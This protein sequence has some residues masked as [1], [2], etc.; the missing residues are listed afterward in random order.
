MLAGST[1]SAT[2]L[3]EVQG[4]LLA[5]ARAELAGSLSGARFRYELRYSGQ[6]FEL[7]V[8]EELEST[9]LDALEHTEQRWAGMDPLALRAAFAAAHEQRYGYRD[10]DAE[11]ELVNVRVSVWGPSPPLSPNLASSTPPA[12]SERPIV[13]D[14]RPLQAS[15]FAGELPP[16]T[17]VAGP[18]LCALPEATLLVP[19]GW[20][21]TVDDYGTIHLSAVTR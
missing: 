7:P 17:L 4:A 11:I 16:G 6:S 14:G 20:S 5:Q 9:E 21:G 12:R 15:V 18:A 13:F 1:L 19:P 3:A 10:E 2:R 8:E